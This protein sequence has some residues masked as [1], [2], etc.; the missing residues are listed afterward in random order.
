MKICLSVLRDGPKQIIESKIS[1]ERIKVLYFIG[2][3]FKL[4]I[5]CLQA[6]IHCV[7]I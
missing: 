7:L 5:A 6:V 3:S 4:F 1:F 2:T